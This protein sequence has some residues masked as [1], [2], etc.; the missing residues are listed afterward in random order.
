MLVTLIAI[1]FFNLESEANPIDTKLSTPKPEIL[2]NAELQPESASPSLAAPEENDEA[3]EADSAMVFRPLFVY[4][5]Q[6]AQRR[7]IYENRPNWNRRTY[8]PTVYYPY[9]YPTYGYPYYKPTK[10]PIRPTKKPV[11]KEPEFPALF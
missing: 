3:M 2:E 6:Q 4:R 8:Y 10:K 5:K 7:R 9:G 11:R 1:Q